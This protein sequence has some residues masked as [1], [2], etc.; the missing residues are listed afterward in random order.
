MRTLART[1][2]FPVV[3]ILVLA[4]GIGANS[5]MFTLVS[6]LLLKPLDGQ[7]D[8]LVGLYSHDRTKPKSSYRGFAYANYVDIRDRNDVVSSLMAHT[9]SMVGVPHGDSTKQTFISVVSSNY[10]DALGVPLAAGARLH[11]RGRAPLGAHPVV[12]VRHEGAALLGQTVRINAIDFTG[13]MARLSPDRWLPLGMFDVVVNDIFKNNG[14]GLADRKNLSLDPVVFVTAPA[15]L[16]MAAPVRDLASGP[17]RHARD[18]AHC[19]AGGLGGWHLGWLAPKVP[20]TR[21]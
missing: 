4:L 9:F 12:I 15:V 6:A 11:P 17:P 21:D 8:E 2:G 14:S 10:F 7:A 20:A 5:A 3:A 19:A 1:P 16:A 18:A 13:T